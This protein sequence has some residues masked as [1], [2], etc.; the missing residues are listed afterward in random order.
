MSIYKYIET[1]LNDIN[2]FPFVDKEWKTMHNGR[3]VK[4]VDAALA[5][6]S[7]FQQAMNG[8]PDKLSREMVADL[9]TQ[10]TYRGLIAT[11]LW[12]GAHCNYIEHFRSIVYYPNTTIKPILNDVYNKLKNNGITAELFNSLC[13]NGGNHIHGLGPSFFTKVFYFM[14][15][16]LG[17]YDIL[18][19]DTQMWRVYN[20]FRREDGLLSRKMS[21]YNYHD[22][23]KYLD[24]LR[25]VPGVNRPDQLEAF[26][27]EKKQSRK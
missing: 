13:R 16:T 24:Y 1:N 10:D 7:W 17:R 6:Y 3:G 20:D 4:E 22:Y 25:N 21:N 15:L 19:L 27:F 9:Y 8:I 11:L 23:Q 5:N 12:G 2:Q 14:S 18:I 26:L